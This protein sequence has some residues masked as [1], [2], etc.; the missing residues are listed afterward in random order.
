MALFQNRNKNLSR[1]TS[2][3]SKIGEDK[4]SS[5]DQ[6]QQQEQQAAEQQ[7]QADAAAKA[8]AEEQAQAEAQSNKESQEQE[9]E[10]GEGKPNAPEVPESNKP[11]VDDNYILSYLNEKFESKYEDLESFT[12]E[13][14][15]EK[16]LDPQ[17]KAL[18]D[19]VEKTGLPLS[20]WTEYNKDYSKMSDLEKAREILAEKN[21]YFGKEEVEFKLKDYVF[22]EDVDDPQDKMKKQVAL[23]ELV[24]N[25][26]K[27]L[28]EKRVAL[29]S[30]EARLTE[31]QKKYLEAGKSALE[32]QAQNEA[33]SQESAK[34]FLEA[35]SSFK[36]L[37]LKLDED[38]NVN[39]AV[40]EAQQKDIVDYLEKMP[41]WRNEDGS[42]NHGTVI[43]DGLR[44]RNFD[45]LIKEAYNQGVSVGIEKK[46]KSD[47]N[48]S[49]SS[50]S[51]PQG[52]E[53]QEKGNARE[54]VSK[55]VGGRTKSKLRFGRKN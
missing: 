43:R 20:K 27:E 26:M 12:K 3:I 35:A 4:E 28:E 51:V 36:T 9:G 5:E 25:G 49:D 22:D 6:G 29:P 39:F 17:I 47:K 41:H 55:I 37:E 24:H 2:I 18:N 50:Q 38:L 30:T 7:A 42:L 46:V 34:K 23:K 19:W 14:V 13:K 33:A 48:I 32:L 21:P 40:E 44:M 8:A 53:N 10:G 52:G 1:A 54:I 45:N 15:V 31:D 11:E 16:E